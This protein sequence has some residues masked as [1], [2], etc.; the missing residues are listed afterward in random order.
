MITKFD[1]GSFHIELN[2]NDF[3]RLKPGKHAGRSS[4]INSDIV[5]YISGD[6][7]NKR[8]HLDTE[9]IKDEAN[10]TYLPEGTNVNNF[11]ILEVKICNKSY[12]K[13]EKIGKVYFPYLYGL[14]LEIIRT[15]FYKS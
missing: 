3:L 10:I 5:N 7:M 11:E 13:L 14:E 15:E 9:K 4:I 12:E 8:C 1:L 2:E 6:T